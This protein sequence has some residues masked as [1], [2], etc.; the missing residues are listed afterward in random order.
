V[1]CQRSD[2]QGHGALAHA[3]S[4][5]CMRPITPTIHLNGTGR[6][7][8]LYQATGAAAAVARAQH[9]L[10]DA[11]PHGRDYYPQGP[12]A[13]GEAEAQFKVWQTQLAEVY[14]GL[15][16]FAERIAEAGQ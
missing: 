5:E 7:D 12:Q 4:T 6:V 1:T 16:R 3:F 11:W 9:A 14:R 2:H 15:N 10:L 13:L 8:L